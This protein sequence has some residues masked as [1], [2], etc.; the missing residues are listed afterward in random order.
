MRKLFCFLLFAFLLLATANAQDDDAIWFEMYDQIDYTELRK[1]IDEGQIDSARVLRD[2]WWVTVK[3]KEGKFFDTKITPQTPIADHLYEAGI[4]V[5]FEH[6]SDDDEGGEIPKWRQIFLNILPLLIFIVFFIVI[7]WWSQKR[8][9]KVQDEC[10]DRAKA[11]NDEF[12]DRQQKQFE[13]FIE[14]FS[15]LLKKKE[16]DG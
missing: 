6:W 15:A 9:R 1:L 11:I 10:L 12:L 16:S 3:T 4:P 7:L 13:T 14:D 5:K 2:G 8:G